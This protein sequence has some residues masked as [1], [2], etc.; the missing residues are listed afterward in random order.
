MLPLFAVPVSQR[1]ASE[2]RRLAAGLA[3]G[4]NPDEFGVNDKRPRGS[5]RV[6]GRRLRS[7]LM[8]NF[9]LKGLQI[10]P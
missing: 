1:D 10:D 9:S 6:E 7:K 8:F 3:R 4:N 2:Q 5:T